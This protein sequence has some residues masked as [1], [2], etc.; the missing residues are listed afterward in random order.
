MSIPSKT[1]RSL[2]GLTE[3]RDSLI[4]KLQQVEAAIAAAFSGATTSATPAKKRGRKPG[5]RVVKATVAKVSPRAKKEPAAKSVK[6]TAKRGKRG[7]LKEQI[8]G[9]LKK[10]GSKGIGVKQISDKLGVKTA[11]VHVWFGTT[12]KTAGVEKVSPGVYRLK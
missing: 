4:S 9:L 7:A 12:G 2:L 6:V 8:L 11:N 1:L 10:S 5:S 3:K